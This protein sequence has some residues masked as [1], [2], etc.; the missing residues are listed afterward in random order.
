MTNK[1]K[2]RSSG[3]REHP[4]KVTPHQ[5]TA[6]SAPRRGLLDGLLSPR[7]ADT[8]MPKKSTS[9]G[10]GVIA[11]VSSPGLL[12]LTIGVVLMA[13]LC[14]VALGFQGPFSVMASLLALPPI[15]T[16]FDIAMTSRLFVGSGL[17]GIFVLILV[18]SVLLGLFA[19]FV[20]DALQE[21]RAD[22]WTFVR[23]LRILPVTLAANMLALGI[24]M[25][26]TIL[27]GFLGAGL[28]L[29]AA[30]AAF[31]AGVYFLCFAPVIAIAEGRR[32][33]DALGRSARAARMP[34]TTNLTLAGMYA[35]ASIAVF[36]ASSRGPLG[37]NP[38]PV[39]WALVLLA[40]VLHVVL[41]ATL[42]FRY[43]SIA[44][45]V[46]DAPTAKAG[47]AGTRR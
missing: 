11:T 14:A 42:A 23:G 10:R 34:G 32:M 22:R 36:V 38:S 47:R 12:G 39:G 2:K 6:G 31:A 5:E 26:G 35:I 24:T 43:L 45:D 30:I 27:S 16:S 7:Y 46:P 29:L 1:N 33:A 3:F 9:L 13:W 25:V 21:T 17:I 20:V 41:L 19:S 15:G 37:V 28:G 18:R 40:N 44:D 4:P 8:S